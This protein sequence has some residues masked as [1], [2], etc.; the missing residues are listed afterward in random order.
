MPVAPRSSAELVQLIHKSGIAS[1]ARIAAAAPD[2]AAL[3]PEPRRAAS[4]LIHK[5]ILTR[6][7]TEQLLQGRH[8]GF[9]LGPHII[10]DL[11]GKGGMG[12]VYL[13]EHQDLH[14]KVAIKVMVAPCDDDQKLANE[15]FLREARAAAALDHPNIVRI[16]DVARHNGTPYLAM[17]YVD[18]ETL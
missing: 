18:G 12:A 2:V 11:L 7:Q 4:A 5:G 17:E 14:R 10:L 9:V 6:F 3:P 1:P 15:R 8:K 13:A 16:F